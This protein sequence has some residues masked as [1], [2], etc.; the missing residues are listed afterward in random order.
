MVVRLRAVAAED[1]PL[2]TAWQGDPVFEGEFNDF[3]LP[4]RTP[5]VEGAGRGTV[6][7]ADGG[8]LVVEA[9]AQV[10]GTVSWHTVRYGPNSESSCFNIGIALAPHGR[11][12]GHGSTAQRMLADYL[13]VTTAINR[14]EASTDVENVA[15]QRALER[16]GFTREGV[17]RG[18]QFR[19]G[20]WHDLVGYSRL[21]SDP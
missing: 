16:A 10:V 12:Q 11:G 17:I 4:R 13:F 7:G 5:L 18:A 8:M 2:L 15:E 1:V 21:R 3:G 14:V 9:D 19:R 6:V 20:G